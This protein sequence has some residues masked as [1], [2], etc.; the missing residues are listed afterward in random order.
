MVAPLM[1]NKIPAK[2]MISI[3]SWSPVHERQSLPLTTRLELSLFVMN[4][5]SRQCMAVLQT[6]LYEDNL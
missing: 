4:S 1:K 2:D 6:F 3:Q 5:I